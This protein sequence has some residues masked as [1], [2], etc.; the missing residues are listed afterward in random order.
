MI[1]FG[2]S[3]CKEWSFYFLSCSEAFFCCIHA[4]DTFSASPTSLFKVEQQV[5]HQM[6]TGYVYVFTSRV[7]KDAGR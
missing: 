7:P 1:K 2:W 5:I 3:L 4:A 6:Y